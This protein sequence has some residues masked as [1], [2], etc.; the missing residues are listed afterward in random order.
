MLPS[1]FFI[2]PFCC[3]FLYSVFFG[4][5]NCRLEKRY[6]FS[7]RKS[8]GG[9]AG[10]CS[11]TLS[12]LVC[13]VGCFYVFSSQALPSFPPRRSHIVAQPTRFFKRQ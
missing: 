9:S 11:R 10:T 2:F 5:R 6:F 3:F 4:D 12:S 13:E 7:N 8:F 1:P